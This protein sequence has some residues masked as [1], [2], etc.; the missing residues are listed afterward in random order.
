M[1]PSWKSTDLTRRCTGARKCLFR[2]FS[3]STMLPVAT[4]L[5]VKASGLPPSHL[6]SRNV[7]Q[8]SYAK[9]APQQVKI[10]HKVNNDTWKQ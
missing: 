8:W 3:S 2:S 10:D 6:G 4:N 1:A 9:S 7:L 5:A